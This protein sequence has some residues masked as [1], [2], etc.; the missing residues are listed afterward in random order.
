MTFLDGSACSCQS[1]AIRH[2]PLAIVLAATVAATA[3]HAAPCSPSQKKAIGSAK[4]AAIARIQAA[5]QAIL[6]KSPKALDASLSIF[7]SESDQLDLAGTL[8]RMNARLTGSKT[9][10]ACEPASSS[11]CRSNPGFV[12]RKD[13]NAIHLCSRFFSGRPEQR[14]RALVHEAAHLSGIFLLGAEGYCAAYD[15]HSECGGGQD[16]AN[17]ADNWAHLVHCAGGRKPDAATAVTQRRR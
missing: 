13:R 12:A 11:G 2:H 17:Q 16:A 1:E 6:D 10:F 15:C 14:V 3:A 5:T 8:R 7:G 9:R 4:R